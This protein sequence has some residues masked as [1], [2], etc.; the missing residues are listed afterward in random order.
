[1]T[2][3]RWIPNP[4]VASV[5]D[6]DRVVIILLTDL[7]ASGPRI[8]SGSAAEIWRWLDHT[9]SEIVELIARRHGISTNEAGDALTAFIQQLAG[10]RLVVQR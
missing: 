8:L 4:D 1:M 3:R 5:D 10:E 9:E 2:A 7:G 6:G